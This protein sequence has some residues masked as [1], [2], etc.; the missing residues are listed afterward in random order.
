MILQGK[1]I[2]ITRPV[3]QAENISRLIENL[4]GSAIRMPA[5]AIEE[6]DNKKEIITT[7]E[8][9]DSFQWVIF[10]SA[11]AVNFALRANSGKI[12]EIL[13]ANI[14]AIGQATADALTNAGLPVHLLPDNGFSTEDLLAMPGMQDVTGQDILIVRGVGGREQLASILTSRAAK[15]V[16]Y[17]EVYK[18]TLPVTDFQPLSLMLT[19]GKLAVVTVTSGEILQNLLTMLDRKYHKYLFTLPLVVVSDRIRQMAITM[20]FKQIVMAKSPSDK[21]QLEAIIT[22]VTGENSG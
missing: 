6:T 19:E 3:H 5:M 4:G 14:A 16:K 12:P 15:S 2:L 21:A 20:G 8:S 1:N 22:S 11:N 9:L 10:I 7:L 18:R 17:L 13:S